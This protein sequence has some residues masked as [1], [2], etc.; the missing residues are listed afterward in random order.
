[1]VLLMRGA[2]VVIADELLVHLLCDFHLHGVITWSDGEHVPL[3]LIELTASLEVVEAGQVNHDHENSEAC[4]LGC[5]LV[6]LKKLL[7]IL[8][9]GEADKSAGIAVGATLFDC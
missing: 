4:D 6:L 3:D 7:L 5:H 1:M 2:A 9:A 8:L